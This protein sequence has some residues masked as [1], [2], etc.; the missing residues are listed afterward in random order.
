MARI[1][2]LGSFLSH[3]SYSPGFLTSGGI[4]H[5]NARTDLMSAAIVGYKYDTVIAKFS[6]CE[7]ELVSPLSASGFSCA[8]CRKEMV[9]S[10][11]TTH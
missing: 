1:H 9:Q 5:I 4:A 10:R 8:I 11:Q 3:H 2:K 7:L 6:F